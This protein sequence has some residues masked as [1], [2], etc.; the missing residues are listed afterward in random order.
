LLC[1]QVYHAA[2]GERRAA[3]QKRGVSVGDYQQQAE[4]PG[5][6]E[7]LPEEGAVHSQV[8]QDV[9]QR[10]DR[11]F[12]ACLRRVQAGETPDYPRLHERSR[13]PR[14]TSPQVGNGVT[15]DHDFL[16]LSQLGR[17]AVRWSRPLEGTPKTPKTAQDR[18]RP[19]RSAGK[20]RGGRS[21]SPA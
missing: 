18:P 11:A 10:V 15:M 6:K 2:V 4:L 17:L 9:V 8:L 19:P 20:R 21:P 14:L 3:W 5:I 13:C 12:R 7:A 1:R 16:V